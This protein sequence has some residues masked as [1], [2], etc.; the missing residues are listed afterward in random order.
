MFVFPIDI[1]RKYRV[2][3]RIRFVTFIFVMLLLTA[4]GINGLLGSLDAR[5][6]TRQEYV[7]V[8]VAYGDTL[9]DIAKEYLGDTMDVRE[10]V[11]RIMTEN[12]ISAAELQP[13]QTLKIPV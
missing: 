5:G 8:T 10:A 9:W 1:K 11:H 7:T 4:T 12:G 6:E 2:K 13:G 3:S